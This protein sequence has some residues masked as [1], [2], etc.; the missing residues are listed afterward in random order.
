MSRH[1]KRAA[2]IGFAA[3]SIEG[4]LISP[5]QVVAIASATPDQKTAADYGCPKG[6]SLRDEITRYFRI[7]QAHWRAYALIEAPTVTQ[8]AAFAQIAARRS[9]RVQSGRSRH[10]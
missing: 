8:T 3:I 1:N 6:T 2:D 5:E 9:V 4:G 7:G 10:P